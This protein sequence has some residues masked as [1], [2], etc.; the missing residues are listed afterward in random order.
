MTDLSRLVMVFKQCHLDILH[1]DI[2]K[3]LQRRKTHHIHPY[4]SGLL[5]F[6]TNALPRF[7]ASIPTYHHAANGVTLMN[8]VTPPMKYACSVLPVVDGE[9]VYIMFV[10]F[11]DPRSQISKITIDN[12]ASIE[13]LHQNQR[14]PAI[15]MLTATMK[16]IKLY[17]GISVSDVIDVKH[18]RSL[19]TRADDAT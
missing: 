1:T 18:T 14:P 11:S 19:R 12:T 6:A 16:N 3:A 5:T 2:H 4:R 9:E 8:D 15:C 17:T 13:L 10:R 7:S